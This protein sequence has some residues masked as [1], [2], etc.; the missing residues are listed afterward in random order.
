MESNNNFESTLKKSKQRARK[1]LQSQNFTEFFV[2]N[3]RRRVIEFLVTSKNTTLLEYYFLELL[4]QEL[5]EFAKL[6]IV[7]ESDEKITH[8][9]YTEELITLIFKM[10]W[11]NGA[12]ETSIEIDSEQFEFLITNTSSI[13]IQMFNYKLCSTFLKNIVETQVDLITKTYQDIKEENFKYNSK[14]KKLTQFLQ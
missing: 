7:N 1:A 3:D 9:Y 14:N 8:W 5:R 10:N 13:G 12:Q 4:P 6:E 11:G 2:L